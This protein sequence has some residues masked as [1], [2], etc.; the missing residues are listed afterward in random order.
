MLR[1]EEVE[2]RFVSGRWK[3]CRGLEVLVV[4]AKVF[5]QQLDRVEVDASS[6]RKSTKGDSTIVEG[7]SRGRAR[8]DALYRSGRA[9]LEHGLAIRCHG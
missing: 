5:E 6:L 3:G 2:L 7:G 1:G 4:K 8:Q 9:T